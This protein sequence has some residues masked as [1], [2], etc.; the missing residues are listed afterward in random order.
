MILTSHRFVNF[1]RALKQLK[2]LFLSAKVCPALLCDRND[3]F[4]SHHWSVEYNPLARA[5]ICLQTMLE[6]VIIAIKINSIFILIMP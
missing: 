3:E 4:L 2:S 6:L 1:L 5:S